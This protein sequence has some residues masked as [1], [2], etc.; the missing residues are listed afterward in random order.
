MHGKQK[1]PEE[2]LRDLE[3]RQRNIVFPDTVQNEARFWRSLGKGPFSTS[4]KAGLVVLAIFVFVW[5][6]VV[7][8][9]TYA[10]GVLREFVLAMILFC[11]SIFGAIAWATRRS[12]RNIENGRRKR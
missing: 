1:Q 9:A 12:L 11:G 7:L 5:A 8:V 6:A 4:A 2:W 10:G 3:A